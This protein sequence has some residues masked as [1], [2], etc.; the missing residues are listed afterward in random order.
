M[1]DTWVTALVHFV[2]DD[3]TVALPAPGRPARRRTS[4]AIAGAGL[5]ARPGEVVETA[6]RC[7]RRPGRLLVRRQEAPAQIR[8]G[9]TACDDTCDDNGLITD[10]QGTPWDLTPPVG[11]SP[12]RGA[13]G[14]GRPRIVEV[15]DEQYDLLRTVPLLDLRAERV[16]WKATRCALTYWYWG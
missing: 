10:W 9:C 5:V 4:G 3:P 14:A 13:R 2:P 7:R 6:L 1:G 8:W 16:V 15:A 11:E 12:P